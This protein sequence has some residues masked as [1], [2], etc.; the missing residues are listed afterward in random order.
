MAKKP[1]TD[2]IDDFE[3]ASI[4]EI[5]FFFKSVD[6]VKNEH[7]LV[8]ALTKRRIA[9]VAQ[10]LRVPIADYVENIFELHFKTY[11]KEIKKKIKKQQQE[12]SKDLDLDL[13]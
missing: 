11:G 4:E 12:D 9:Y 8:S 3:T 5:D 13:D 1:N 2:F 7:L 10:T 6:G